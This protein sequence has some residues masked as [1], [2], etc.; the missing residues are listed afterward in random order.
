LD[1]KES[2]CLT[3]LF[4]VPEELE[5]LGWDNI[6]TVTLPHPRTGNPAL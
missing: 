1:V 3:K 6:S 2:P 5:S 4:V